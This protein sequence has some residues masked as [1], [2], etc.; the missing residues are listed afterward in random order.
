[1]TIYLSLLATKR[2]E[3]SGAPSR[4]SVGGVDI[5]IDDGGHAVDQQ[6]I[7]LEEMLSNLRPGGVYLCED[8]TGFNRFAAFASGLVHELNSMQ[9]SSSLLESSV[10][11]FQSSIHSIHFYPH[12]VVIEKHS[13]PLLKLSWPKRGVSRY[14]TGEVDIAFP[15]GRLSA[16]IPYST[17]PCGTV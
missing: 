9:I 4:K 5:L 13:V 12:V 8:V 2:I 14:Y 1:M 6:Q 3:P 11:Q 15:V 17:V 10:S 7:T 16:V